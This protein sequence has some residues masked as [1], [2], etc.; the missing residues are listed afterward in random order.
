MINRLEAF[1]TNLYLLGRVSFSLSGMRPSR[2][3]GYLM[4]ILSPLGFAFYTLWFFNLLP[5]LDPDLVVKSTIYLL[6]LFFFG[7]V[8]V[9]GY[10]VIT[11][12]R[13]KESVRGGSEHA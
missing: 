5:G 4:I 12:P 8:G 11:A 7:V 13:P 3:I 2:L 6:A 10:L 1:P 9:L